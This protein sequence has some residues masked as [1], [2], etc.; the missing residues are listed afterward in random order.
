MA[1]NLTQLTNSDNGVSVNVL[2]ADNKLE[3]YLNPDLSGVTGFAK[4]Y[5]TINFSA[6]NTNSVLDIS[7]YLRAFK[8][9]NP[10]AT[11][12]V[13]AVCMSNFI[14]GG[15][16]SYTITGNGISLVPQSPSLSQWTSQI[17]SYVV[18]IY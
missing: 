12:V 6:I 5:E 13:M 3:I 11:S 15:N 1:Q 17:D 10:G 7:G 18:N 2:F 16:F 14:G 4:A 9:A 8:Q